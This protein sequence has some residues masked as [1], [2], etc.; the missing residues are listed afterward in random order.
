M[1]QVSAHAERGLVCPPWGKGGG[2]RCVKCT[3]ASNSSG[4][5]SWPYKHCFVR[6][7]YADVAAALC[8]HIHCCFVHNCSSPTVL[9]HCLARDVCLLSCLFAVHAAAGLAY[10]VVEPPPE[11]P[12]QTFPKALRANSRREADSMLRYISC[13]CRSFA[14]NQTVPSGHDRPVLTQCRHHP[15]LLPLLQV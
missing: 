13:K 12:L 2:C 10:A 4:C 7:T 9:Q 15:P 5:R 3:C 11:Q 8:F 6:C 14:T 1:K